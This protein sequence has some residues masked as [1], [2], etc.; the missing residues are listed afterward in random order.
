MDNLDDVTAQLDA[1]KT[2]LKSL[3]NK[4]DIKE[5][6][7]LELLEMFAKVT[8]CSSRQL[9]LSVLALLRDSLFMLKHIPHQMD[10]LGKSDDDTKKM[11]FA[12]N[13]RQIIAEY[14]VC[15]PGSFADMPTD[16]LLVFVSNIA[17]NEIIKQ[18]VIYLFVILFIYLLICYFHVV[19]LC[20]PSNVTCR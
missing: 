7:A 11:L 2:Q 12:E 10:C 13:L 1:E 8:K 6:I 20:T 9:M 5:A 19:F 16:K 4:T 14:F 17:D 3:L 18:Q 15:F